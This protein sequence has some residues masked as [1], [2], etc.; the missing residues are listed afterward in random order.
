[1]TLNG[2]WEGFYDAPAPFGRKQFSLVI[3]EVNLYSI[4][5][6]HIL[7]L[8]GF[9]AQCQCLQLHQNKSFAWLSFEIL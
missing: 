2:K 5:E 7:D 4:I 8:V 6:S 3:S 9:K 1:M